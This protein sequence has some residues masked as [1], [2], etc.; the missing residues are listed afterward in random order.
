[1]A[2]IQDDMMPSKTTGNLDWEGNS[3]HNNISFQNVEDIEH[4][5]SREVD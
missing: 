2:F 3:N 4:T 5:A 1:M